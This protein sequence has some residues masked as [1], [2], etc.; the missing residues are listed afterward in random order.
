MCRGHDDLAAKGSR[1]PI[2]VQ[3]GLRI[4]QVKPGPNEGCLTVGN[5]CLKIGKLA[6][7]M[8]FPHISAHDRNLILVPRVPS[9]RSLE[10]SRLY[11]LYDCIRFYRKPLI[12]LIVC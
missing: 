8:G 12:T 4:K 10:S 6:L 9:V 1:T 11:S 7:T 2:A 5:S 3:A